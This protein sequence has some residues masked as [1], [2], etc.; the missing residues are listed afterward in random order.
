MNLFEAADRREQ[1]GRLRAEGQSL[2]IHAQEAKSPG[3][4]EKIYAEIVRIARSKEFVH[5]NDLLG[6]EEPEHPNAYGPIWQRLIAD[7]VLEWTSTFQRC[8]DP[9]KRGRQSPVYRSLIW[10]RG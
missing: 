9:K 4:S 10:R 5:V 1:A 3:W 7:K 6:F 2:A 8:V